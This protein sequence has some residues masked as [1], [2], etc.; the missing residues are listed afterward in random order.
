MPIMNL[1][2]PS[3]CKI[4]LLLNILGRRADGFHELET[5]IH[6]IS[7]FDLLSFERIGHGLQLSCSNAS[8]PADSQ[9]LVHRAASAFLEAAKITDGVQ[10]HLEKHLPLAAVPAWG[11]GKP[12]P[13]PL[14]PHRV[15]GKPPTLVPLRTSLPGFVPSMPLFLPIQP[16]P[17]TPR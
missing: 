14:V 2:K 11:P 10:I 4:N 5:V 13:N 12:A 7:L 16:A 8:L 6:P 17:W 1:E 3:P 15:F 9:N